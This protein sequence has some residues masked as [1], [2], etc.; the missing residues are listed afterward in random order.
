MHLAFKT[1]LKFL[2]KLLVIGTRGQY[3]CLVNNIVI[4]YHLQLEKYYRNPSLIINSTKA[5]L[6][7]L[8]YI[9]GF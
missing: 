6:L 4:D 8:L 9:T 2:D 7:F 3:P 1:A 5:I